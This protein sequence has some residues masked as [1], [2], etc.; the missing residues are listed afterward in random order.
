M[1]TKNPMPNSGVV[2]KRTPNNT[3]IQL[4][5]AY[6]TCNIPDRLKATNQIVVG[7]CV[8]WN[9][10]QYI[11]NV[12]P[13]RNSFSRRRVGNTFD[14]QIIAA[15]VDQVI[16]V[17]AA[18]KPRI[19]WNLLDRYLVS[20]EFSD[21]PPL[22][23]ITKMDLVDG[24]PE[25][26]EIV[27]I[28]E[29][30]QTLGY[31]VILTST[32]KDQGIAELRSY[33]SGRLSVLVGKSGVGKSSLINA[34]SPEFALR[35]QDVSK[36]TNKGRHTTTSSQI[37]PLSQAGFIMDTPGVREFGLWD[38]TEHDLIMCFPEMRAFQHTCKFKDCSHDDEPGC[39]IRKAV[40]QG[41]IS[42]YRYQSYLKLKGEIYA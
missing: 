9:D 33:L 40:M 26:E 11:T 36:A 24:S 27:L 12:L 41:E 3:T 19:S 4:G 20:A 22:V 6:I 37:F 30:Y 2:I 32:T 29:E 35:T 10:A 21:I 8:N 15:N 14:E 7:D 38:V 13:R 28:A 16:I 34:L 5:D 42:P 17:L 31:D 18:A 25:A 1:T 39:A 23:C